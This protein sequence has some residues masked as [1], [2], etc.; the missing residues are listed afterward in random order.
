VVMGIVLQT[1]FFHI[2]GR[3]RGPLAAQ[4]PNL[5]RAA[6]AAVGTLGS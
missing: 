6:I 3:L 5:A 4:A 2:Y 1:A